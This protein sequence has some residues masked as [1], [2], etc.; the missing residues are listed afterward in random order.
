MSTKM[1]LTELFSQQSISFLSEDVEVLLWIT[2]S[3]SRS[4]SYFNFIHLIV[5]LKF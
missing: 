4:G 1:A 3:A 5:S 2:C